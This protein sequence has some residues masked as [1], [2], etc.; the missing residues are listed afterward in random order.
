MNM[1][2]VLFCTGQGIGNV[3]QCTPVIETLSTCLDFEVDF[4][5]A[6]GNYTIPRNLLPNVNKV[7]IGDEIYNINSSDYYGKV[8][9][10]WI[11]HHSRIIKVADSVLKMPKLAEAAKLVGM[12]RSEVDV[13]MDIARQLGVCEKDIVWEGFCNYNHLNRKYDI[14]IHNGYNRKNLSMTWLV[15]EYPYY[16]DLATV[17]IRKGFSVC[18]IGAEDEYVSSTTN[19]TGLDLL[20]SLGIIRNCRLF[21]LNDTGTYHCAN[22]LKVPNIVIFTATSITKNYDPRFHNYSTII[23]REDLRCRLS[24]QA[25]HSWKRCG[26]WEC[27]NIKPEIIANIVREMLN[28]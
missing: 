2:R 17:F 25:N 6:Y 18:S 8:Y 23:S 10:G 14:V 24:C 27:R 16:E 3:I 12:K 22:A 1:K 4:W 13:N 28:G 19:E 5:H 20:D 9:T 15:K 11:R 21:I 26:N 7:F